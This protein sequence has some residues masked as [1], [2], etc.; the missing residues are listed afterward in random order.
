MNKNDTVRC[1]VSDSIIIE[2]YLNGYPLEEIEWKH[3]TNGD[4]QNVDNVLYFNTSNK[5]SQLF[6]EISDITKSQQGRYMCVS[7]SNKNHQAKTDIIVQSN[8][9]HNILKLKQS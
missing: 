6:L 9:A 8:F 4:Y 3:F 7:K 2:C 5:T 1:N